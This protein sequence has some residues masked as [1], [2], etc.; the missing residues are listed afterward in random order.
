MSD[1]NTPNYVKLFG[2]IDF[3]E[4]N[5]ARSVYSPAAYLADLL[6]LIEDEM[7]LPNSFDPDYAKRLDERHKD[8]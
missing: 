3:R 7:H 8:I 2:D 4:G 1:K 5:E 6:Q